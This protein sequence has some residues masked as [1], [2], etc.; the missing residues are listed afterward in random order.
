MVATAEQTELVS[1]NPATLEPVGRV[2]VTP[3]EAVQEAVA[4]ARLAQERW[5]ETSWRERRALLEAVW[6][7]TLEHADEIRAFEAR[8]K[9]AQPWLFA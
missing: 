4:E 7:L 5:A 9:Q 3:P 2:P 1:L 6:R 8:H